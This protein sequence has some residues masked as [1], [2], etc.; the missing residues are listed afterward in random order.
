MKKTVVGIIF[1]FIA[2]LSFMLT[3]CGGSAGD[4][5]DSVKDK[6]SGGGASVDEDPDAPDRDNTPQVLADEATG[7]KTFDGGGAV[8]DY[9]NASA[10]YFMVK[11]EGDTDKIKVLVTHESD[12]AYTYDLQ[13]NGDFNTFPFS[14]GNGKYTV[15]VYE[16]V[17]GDKYATAAEKKIEVKIKDEFSPFLHPN[18]YA[19]FNEGSAC[20]AKAQE[21]VTGSK[22]DL[23]ATEQVFL[24]VVDN[25]TYDYD[26]AASVQSGYVPDPDATLQSGTGICFD[27]ASLTTSMLRSQG[28]PCQLVVGYAGSAYH[29]WIE[30]YSKESGEVASIMEFS[31]DKYNRADPTFVASGDNADPNVVGDGTSYN[32]MYYY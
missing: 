15:G 24:F 32:P 13:L 21:V 2:G 12:E 20:V 14:Q 27:Y 11:Y 8:V 25:V 7:K 22:T 9:S 23:G 26:L 16:N 10:G 19:N 31:G 4:I 29:A 3:A 5:I 1:I 6:V 28:I 18:Q 17:E 30:V